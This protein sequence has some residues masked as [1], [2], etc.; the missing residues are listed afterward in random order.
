MPLAQGPQCNDYIE[1]RAHDP[2]VSCQALYYGPLRS[3]GGGV[4]IGVSGDGVSSGV[5]C[6]DDNGEGD[7]VRGDVMAVLM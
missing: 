7:A 4:S 6:G 1:A 5:D 3:L 2:S